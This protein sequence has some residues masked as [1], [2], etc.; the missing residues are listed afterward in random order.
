[1]PGRVRVVLSDLDDTLFDHAHAT[2]RAL[3]T[4]RD[5]TP[6][7]EGVP[8]D[9]LQAR[10]AEL[11]EA[12]HLEVLAGRVSI[13]DARA[14]RFARLLASAGVT[15]ARER[16]RRVAG[17]YRDAYEASWRAVPGAVALLASLGRAGVPVVI[18]T[19]NVEDEQRV[20]LERCGL[21]GAITA[22]VTSEREGVSKPDV[23][24][25]ASALRRV[26]AAAAEAVMFGDAWAADIAGARQ[27]GI[28][29]VWLNR[30]GAPRP[31]AAVPEVTALEP[32]DAV[33]EALGV[34]TRS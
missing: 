12:L 24:I 32:V 7:L 14:E 30:F 3:A 19:N 8:L 6:G 11:L 15:D 26:S 20:K 23:R 10:H 28:R 4:V 22:L 17:V 27:A 5:G 21:A 29:A 34:E 9:D 1:M 31:D 13:A 18:V 25:F 2:R 16:S 33:V